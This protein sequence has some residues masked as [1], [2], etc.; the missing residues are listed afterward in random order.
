MNS[1]TLAWIT[2]TILIT[3][4][5]AGQKQSKSNPIAHFPLPSEYVGSFI[6][7]G[8]LSL[9]PG[10][11]GQRVAGLFGWGLVVATALNLWDTNGAVAQ[12]GKKKSNT[13]AA[14]PAAVTA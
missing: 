3:Y 4:R 9:V 8:A 12:L 14:A 13:K 1:L 10:P 6:I 7:Y 11:Q 2:E 5:A